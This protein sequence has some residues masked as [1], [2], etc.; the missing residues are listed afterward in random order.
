LITILGIVAGFFSTVSFLPQLIKILRT[1]S[2]ED[3]SVFM[4]VLFLTGVFLWII[5]GLLI[6]SFPVVATNASIGVLALWILLLKFKYS[7]K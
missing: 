2:V 4:Y 7:G 3:I 1:K 5:Y 6:A